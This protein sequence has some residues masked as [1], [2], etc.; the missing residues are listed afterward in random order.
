MRKEEKNIH[1]RISINSNQN[2]IVVKKEKKKVH[3][4][5]QKYVK[6]LYT[7]NYKVLTSRSV[8]LWARLLIEHLIRRQL[9]KKGT[10]GQNRQETPTFWPSISFSHISWVGLQNDLDSPEFEFN[11]YSVLLPIRKCVVG[12]CNPFR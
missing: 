1:L 6:T 2:S 4:I 10:L 5:L 7:P 11:Q 3:F 9:K 12:A 8:L